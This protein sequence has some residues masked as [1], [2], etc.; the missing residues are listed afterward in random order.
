MKKNYFIGVL[1]ITAILIGA[2]YNPFFPPA[3]EKSDDGCSHQYSDWGTKTEATCAAE[4]VQEKICS[5]CG[6]IQTQEI[7]DPLEHTPGEEATCADDQVCTLCGDVI[8]GALGHTF[9]PSATC[10]DDQICTVCDDVITDAHGHTPGEAATCTAAQVC[11]DCDDVIEGARGHAFSTIPATCI[12]ESI[13]GTCTREDCDEENQEAVV[14]ELG[15]DWDWINYI[16]GSG[17]R[18]CQRNDDC[19]ITAGIGDTGPGGGIIFFVADGVGFLADNT[20]PKPLGF[21]LFLTATDAVGTTAYYLEASTVATLGGTGAQTTMRWSIRTTSPYPTVNIAN[22]ASG[23]GIGTGKRNT[24][25]IIAAEEAERPVENT[26][27]YAALACDNYSTVTAVDWFLPSRDELNELYKERAHFG[28]SSGWFW[29]SSQNGSLYAWDQNFG[30]GGQ[31]YGNKN[32]DTS[33]RPVRA[34]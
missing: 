25:I 11:T 30:S 14:T 22:D 28:I 24:A 15:H 6:D 16:S 3:K 34:F 20:T 4:E 18:K 26:Y 2:C 19:T 5:L 13:P 33:V 17:L 9:G 8:E 32:L 1:I 21:T 29:S 23:R 27:I 10:L 7:G 31:S 12:T